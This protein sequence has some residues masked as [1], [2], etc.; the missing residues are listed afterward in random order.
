MWDGVVGTYVVK[1]RVTLLRGHRS[2]SD[3]VVSFA[4]LPCHRDIVTLLLPFVFLDSDISE[5][6]SER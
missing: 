3:L 5:K 2:V 4:F 1:V 6:S